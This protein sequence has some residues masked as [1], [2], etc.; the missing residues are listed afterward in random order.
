MAFRL[1]LPPL[2]PGPVAGEGLV[3]AMLETHDLQ[4]VRGQRLLFEHLELTVSAGDCLQV[5]GDNGAGKTS[6]LRT[7]CG[8][9]APSAGEVRWRGTDIRRAREEFGASLVYVGH[10][11]GVKDDLTATENVR[12]GAAIAGRD[13]DAGSAAAALAQLG[14]S[15]HRHALA[16]HLSQGQKR[17]V[18]LARLFLAGEAP[19]WILDEPFTA[20]DVRGVAALQALI[21]GQLAR[22]GAVVFTTHQAVELPGRVRRLELG[23]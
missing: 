22:G 20:L 9:L 14:L 4:C 16:R 15:A 7:L 1:P 10:L 23:S 5:A 18:A 6:L 8:L 3:R 13:A 11:N 2:R 17:R 19:L 21:A 12:F